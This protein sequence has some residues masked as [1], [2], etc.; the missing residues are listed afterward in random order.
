MNLI[1]KTN[2]SFY[3][4]GKRVIPKSHHSFFDIIN[5]FNEK[6]EAKVP[7]ADHEIVND[8]VESAFKGGQSWKNTTVLKGPVHC[9]DSAKK[10][11]KNALSYLKLKPSTQES[12]IQKLSLM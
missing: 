7:M 4:G 6:I 9:A 8:A 12:H 10:L 3:I 5:P 2:K 1:S 11:K